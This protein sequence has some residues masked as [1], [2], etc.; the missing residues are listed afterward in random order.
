MGQVV[1]KMNGKKKKEDGKSS[2][3]AKMARGG[4]HCECLPG[5]WY[6]DYLFSTIY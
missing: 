2:T 3:E 6:V 4:C 5:T 1:S